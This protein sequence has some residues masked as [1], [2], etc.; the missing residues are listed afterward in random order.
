MN[1]ND[2]AMNAAHLMINE[3]IMMPAPPSAKRAWNSFIGN[4]A[5]RVV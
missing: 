1:E 4:D 5:A 3:R 2:R